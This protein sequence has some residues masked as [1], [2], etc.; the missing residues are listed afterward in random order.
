[1]NILNSASLQ[2]VRD[3]MPTNQGGIYA[4]Q[5]FAYQ[6]DVAAKFYIEMLSNENLIEVACE[7]HDDI[8]LIWKRD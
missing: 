8:V 5:G 7:T 3:T 2:S 6:D 4:R 1:M